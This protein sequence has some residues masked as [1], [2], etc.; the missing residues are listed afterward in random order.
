MDYGLPKGE[1]ACTK[2][3]MVGEHFDSIRDFYVN[4]PMVQKK[5]TEMYAA[6]CPAASFNDLQEHAFEWFMRSGNEIFDTVPPFPAFLFHA[7]AFTEAVGILLKREQDKQ[8][9]NE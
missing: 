9:A 6:L 7:I 2:F 5:V 3:A 4:S 1:T 8:G